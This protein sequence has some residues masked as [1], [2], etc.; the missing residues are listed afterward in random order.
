M[1]AIGGVRCRIGWHG[2]AWFGPWYGGMA[3]N[4]I[5]KQCGRHDAR[6]IAR[7]DVRAFWHHVGDDADWL[8]YEWLPS[9]CPSGPPRPRP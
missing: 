6:Y 4:R 8:T 3:T 5:C 9:G 7:G 2:W 1:T